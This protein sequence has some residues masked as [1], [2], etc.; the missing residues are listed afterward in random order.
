MSDKEDISKTI[1]KIKVY[2]QDKIQI[3]IF[4]VNCNFKAHGY[5]RSAIESRKLIDNKT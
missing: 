4:I 2:F 3:K 5:R 1:P